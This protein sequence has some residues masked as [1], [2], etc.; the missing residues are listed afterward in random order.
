MPFTPA[1]VLPAGVV[2]GRVD[3]FSPILGTYGMGGPGFF[4]LRLDGEWLV[5]A[6]WGAAEWMTAYGRAVGDFFYLA[7]GR[8]KPWLADDATRTQF[9]EQ[10]IGRHVVDIAIHQHSLKLLFAN[11]FD[12][13]IEESAERRPIFQGSR[14]PRAFAAEDDLRRAV[15]LSPTTELWV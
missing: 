5:V 7:N 9:S 10:L 1:P 14:T 3:E 6:L 8:P 15:F 13:T 11:G 12:L 4:G 2:G